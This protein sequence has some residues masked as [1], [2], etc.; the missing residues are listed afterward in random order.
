M[1][2]LVFD[3][4]TSRFCGNL[5]WHRDSYLVS[6]CLK[7]GSEIRTWMF[8]HKDVPYSTIDIAEIQEYFDDADIIVAHNCFSGST[9]YITRDGVKTLKDTVG[10]TQSI[11]TE[12][13]WRQGE[14]KAYGKDKL[15]TLTL[16]PYN[17]SRTSIVKS[18]ETTSNHRWMIN[19]I[20]ITNKYGRQRLTKEGYTTTDELK[21]GDV[22]HAQ[23]PKYRLVKDSD[24]FRHGLIYGDGS[25]CSG[26]QA[27]Q[28]RLCGKKQKYKRYFGDWAYPPSANGDPVIYYYKSPDNLKRVPDVTKNGEYV[29]NFIEGWI[30]T[31]GTK[32][33]DSV[34]VTTVH[35]EAADWLVA[36]A[37]VGG[38]FCTGI[39]EHIYDD[40]FS[41]NPYWMITISKDTNMGWTVKD[42]DR[43]SQI[44]E[45]T[46]C[47]EVP[48]QGRFTLDG[49]IYTANCKFDLH[50]VHHLG[51]NT[52]KAMYY[53]TMVAEYLIQGQ[54]QG[55]ELS[56]K[57]L[58]TKYG[59]PSKI[60]LVGEWWDSGYETDEIPL[61]ILVPYGEQDVLNCEAIYLR[62]IPQIIAQGQSKLVKLRC[63]SLRVTQQIEANGMNIDT[64]LCQDMS[65]DYASQIIALGNAIMIA[66][67]ETLPELRDI[68]I[69]LGSNEQLST[70][71]FGGS[72]SYEGRVDGKREGTT[73][74]GKCYV[75]TNGL[76]FVPRAG[77]E[78]SKAGVYQVD[79]AQ[80][81]GL[82]AKEGTAQYIVLNGI[83]DL[84][85]LEKMKGTYC[86]SLL[87]KHIDSIIHPTINE[88]VTRTGRYSSS[89]PNL[90]NVP[91]EGTSPIKQ[92][93]TT[94]Y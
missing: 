5:P 3:V 71:L 88:C 84:S 72:L 13:G 31:D 43:S 89:A 48:S 68:N 64:L 37:S 16:V 61:D 17:R 54:T 8:N 81:D 80:F 75:D 77:T 36:N 46:F 7:F 83:Q 15:T 14:V 66:I 6:L 58:S 32:R 57:G 26:R 50:W 24:G 25:K 94:R 40:G 52:S 92:I 49:G 90:Q 76:G 60:D 35:K 23:L 91:R 20:K 18:I 85:R 67:K 38:W 86:D 28:I 56:L 74:K 69:N 30:A 44:E 33:K 10:T 51:I 27:Y 4:E 12:N 19:R 55:T 82:K 42:I 34:V 45:D 53:C 29:A 9:Q 73:K 11:W 39:S 47:L 1:K 70:I 21:I 78:T 93:F 65:T 22:I 41:T 2:T 79:S 63:Q 62:Q 87:E 59:I